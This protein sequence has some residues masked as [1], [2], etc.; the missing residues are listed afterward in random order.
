[1][2]LNAVITPAAAFVAFQI[3]FIKNQRCGESCYA[4]V[5]RGMHVRG[6]RGNILEGKLPAVLAA[7]SQSFLLYGLKKK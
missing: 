4:D 2:Q 5:Q 3:S 7:A 1:M 6:M